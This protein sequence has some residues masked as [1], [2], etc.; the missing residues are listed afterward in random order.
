MVTIFCN[1]LG[2]THLER[3]LSSFHAR[4]Y[5]GVASELIDL[6]R[7][8]PLV[9]VPRARA[10]YSA[11]FTS[12]ASLAKARLKEIERVLQRVNPYVR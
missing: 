1:R 10:F 11:G 5:F 7:L 6:M 12:T 8:T 2:W 3:L 4:L 9:S